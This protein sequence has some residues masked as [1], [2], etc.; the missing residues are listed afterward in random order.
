M[1][2]YDEEFEQ[3]V[4]HRRSRLLGVSN[5]LCAGDHA[6]AEDVLQTALVR[7]YLGWRRV[8]KADVD[9]YA[10]RILV[11]TFIDH[12]RRASV[13]R[14]RP[15]DVLLDQA[16]VPEAE[17]FEPELLAALAA[18]PPRMRAAV[19]LRHVV[20]LSVDDAAEALR[21]STGAVKSQTARG[22]SKLRDL[23]TE[24]EGA[25]S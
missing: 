17:P 25:R 8:R 10:R 13:R 21:C 7:L 9:P 15:T 23:L 20:D 4:R 18:L 1:S 24:S 16:A 3:F 11:N 2:T 12:R 14:E 22:L 6:L 19:V 5:A